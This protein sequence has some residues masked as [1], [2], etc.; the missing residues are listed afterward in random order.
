MTIF[1]LWVRKKGLDI[2]PGPFGSALYFRL[3]RSASGVRYERAK[4]VLDHIISAV[5]FAPL[6]CRGIAE[7]LDALPATSHVSNGSTPARHRSTIAMN[8]KR[9]SFRAIQVLR[10]M[11]EVARPK[12]VGPL[13]D[14][15][16][17]L[18][19]VPF[20]VNNFFHT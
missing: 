7:W 20:H 17:C 8:E 1:D 11:I 3:E 19:V 2:N 5:L 16:G 13:C 14:E 18:R 10:T 12:T 4:M 15:R 9:T 6:V